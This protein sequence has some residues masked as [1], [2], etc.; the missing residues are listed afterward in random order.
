MLFKRTENAS[1]KHTNTSNCQ[2]PTQQAQA[3]NEMMRES[4]E[5]YSLYW[6]KYTYT[7][8]I[9]L[10]TVEIMDMRKLREDCISKSELDTIE[11]WYGSQS[12]CFEFKHFG[13]T[14]SNNEVLE[15]ESLVKTEFVD[16]KS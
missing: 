12:S 4:F 1:R 2:P 14:T 15:I 10:F 7:L 3:W 9:N 11:C 13:S 6:H 5:I 8:H 16:G